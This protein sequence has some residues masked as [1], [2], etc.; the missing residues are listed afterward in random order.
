MPLFCDFHFHSKYSRAVSPSM[1]L[2]GLAEGAARKG[3][4]LLGTGDFLHPLW[5]GELKRKLVETEAGS[6]VFRLK[7]GRFAARFILTNEVSTII[8]TPKGVKKAHHIIHAPSFEIVEQISD[9]LSKMGNLSADGRPMFGNTSSAQMAELVFETSRDCLLYAAHCWTP[10][11]SALGSNSGYDSLEECYE[12]QVKNIRALETGMSSDPAMNW[13]VSSLDK[14]ALLSNSD[15]H[16]PYPW[17][18][19]R[20]CNAFNF[21]ADEVTFGKLNDA[22]IKKGRDKFLYTVEVN[23]GYGKYHFDGHRLCGFSC[24]PAESKR[25]GGKCPVCGG[26]LT[27]GVQYRVEELADRPDGFVPPGAIPF[28]TL[29]PLHEV[30]SAVMGSALS[31][32]KVMETADSLI[33]VFGNELNVL[34]NVEGGELLKHSNEQIAEAVL[35]N[36]EGKIEVRPGFDG[37]YGV[38]TIAKGN[39][40]KKRPGNEDSKSQKGLQDYF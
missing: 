17:R 39:A 16:S 3:L 6:G 12:D 11:F 38:P 28:K 37:E 4:G 20:E 29:L 8:S 19:G 22:I 35:L 9:R 14:F 1:S 26:K 27:I 31:S 10:W 24:A 5:F 21:T 23:P 30:V 36:R 15:S 32:K 2:E 25:L 18:L 34:L 40:R 13:R 7:N 33:N